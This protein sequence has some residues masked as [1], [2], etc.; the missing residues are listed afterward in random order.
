MAGHRNIFT[1]FFLLISCFCNADILPQDG[2]EPVTDYPILYV[3]TV[4]GIIIDQKET[5]IDAEAWFDSQGSMDYKSLGS[6]E[7]PLV[8]GIRGR[9]NASWLQDGPKPYKMK[10]EKKQPFFGLT[11]NKHWVL[12]PVSSYG[13]YYNNMVGFKIGQ[14]LGMSYLPSRFPVQL[15]LNGQFVGLYMLGENVR[16][17]EGR[18]DIFEQPD[19]NEDEST[20]PFGWLVEVDNYSDPCQI[21]I[22]HQNYPGRYTRV[23]YHTPEALSTMQEEWLTDQFN[24]FA[25]AAHNVNKLDRRWEEY[26]DINS[27][28]KYFIVQEILNNFDAYMGSWYLYKDLDD[29]RWSVGPLWDMGWS[30]DRTKTSLVCEIDDGTRYNNFMQDIVKFPRFIK[31][32]EGILNDYREHFPED[33]IDSF[34]DSLRVEIDRGFEINREVWPDLSSK[35]GNVNDFA[36]R[37]FKKNLEYLVTRFETD[38]KTY[39][40]S[41]LTD[42]EDDDELLCDDIDDSSDAVVLIND[43]YMHEAEFFSG[44][45]ITLKFKSDYGREV[46]SV[47]INGVEISEIPE[48]NEMVI[49]NIDEDLEIEI[50]FGPITF[51]PAREITLDQEKI[52]L[53]PGETAQ[54]NALV[55][56]QSS[57]QEVLWKSENSDIAEV[58]GNG[59]VTALYPGETNIIAF[60]SEELQAVCS[61]VVMTP[62]S[63]YGDE[64]ADCYERIYISP[65]EIFNISCFTDHKEIVSW[66]SSDNSIASVTENGEIS[67]MEY[68]ETVVRA[69]DKFGRTLAY[70]DVFS[71]PTIYIEHGDGTI[72]AHH[73]LYNSRPK[74]LIAPGKGYLI[75]G[76]THDD[77]NI[78]DSK[79]DEKGY[80]IPLIPIKSDS[81]INICLVSEDVTG[82][83]TIFSDSGVRLYVNGR[84]LYIQGTEPS[85]VV[86]ITDLSGKLVFVEASSEFCFESSGVYL[87]TIDGCE[88][89]YKILI[90]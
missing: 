78:D 2:V 55:S 62:P 76:I 50:V 72:Y 61:V 74:L 86:R 4:D 85:A 66:I 15:V 89:T 27:L 68:G 44:D 32:A 19:N 1:L 47:I 53:L 8:L 54:I 33:W 84:N 59:N 75:A 3:N 41:I 43:L 90:N 5:Y 70:F 17:D 40:I 20:L 71:C 29:S 52:E 46:K 65:E 87:L 11:K 38:L 34:C 64:D 21:K 35:I 48:D 73:V 57:T 81:H 45:K 51:I 14:Q 83:E 25:V 77:V 39:H 69:K 10:F 9:G 7:E 36:K 67:S 22:P 56:P 31:E 23:T 26:I 49:E 6:R 82:S 12:L 63:D 58:D 80:Y 16:I 42:K 18:V 37:Y 28:A 13:E 30:L 79:I 60:V 88:N 24:S